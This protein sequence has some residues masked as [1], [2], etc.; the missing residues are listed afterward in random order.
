[1]LWGNLLR[2]AL[3]E[4]SGPEAL[5][6]ALRFF[7]AM[8]TSPSGTGF[9]FDAN[10]QSIMQY[11]ALRKPDSEQK[12]HQLV[13]LLAYLT[14]K[15][16]VLG[17]PLSD[18]SSLWL[19]EAALDWFFMLGR[20]KGLWFVPNRIKSFFKQVPGCHRWEAVAWLAWLSSENRDSDLTDKLQYGRLLSSIFRIV[21]RVGEGLSKSEISIAVH[22][23]LT[24][25]EDLPLDKALLK[26]VQLTLLIHAGAQNL[27][28]AFVR[29]LRRVLCDVPELA[30][31]AACMLYSKT[32]HL[33]PVHHIARDILQEPLPPEW[34]HYKSFYLINRAFLG[35]HLKDPSF[36]PSREWAIACTKQDMPP[37]SRFIGFAASG[38]WPEA[39][40]NSEGVVEQS[41]DI[42]S[43]APNSLARKLVDWADKVRERIKELAEQM[44]AGTRSWATLLLEFNQFSPPPDCPEYLHP[45]G[46]D[47]LEVCL[48][49]A[50]TLETVHP[51]PR[52]I[53][54]QFLNGIV[55]CAR[56]EDAYVSMLAALESYSRSSEL[57]AS[58]WLQQ[59]NKRM[60][61]NPTHGGLFDRYRTR[62]RNWWKRWE[63]HR[64]LAA[65]TAWIERIK[66]LPMEALQSQVSSVSPSKVLRLL[67]KH[68]TVTYCIPQ[69]H[70]EFFLL[71]AVRARWHIRYSFAKCLLDRDAFLEYEAWL[72]MKNRS[73]Y[74]LANEDTLFPKAEIRYFESVVKPLASVLAQVG[75]NA[76]FSYVPCLSVLAA[77]EKNYRAG[78]PPSVPARTL[79]EP[80]KNLESRHYPDVVT[81]VLSFKVCEERD[82]TLVTEFP[83]VPLFEHSKHLH[84]QANPS[85]LHWLRHNFFP[86]A[87]T[88]GLVGCRALQSFPKGIGQQTLMWEAIAVGFSGIFGSVVGFFEFSKQE[89]IDGLE[90]KE[91][92]D[93]EPPTSATLQEAALRHMTKHRP[94]QRMLGHLGAAEVSQGI[95]WPLKDRVNLIAGGG[96]VGAI[97]TSH[98]AYILKFR[99]E[100]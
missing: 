33:N 27:E 87:Q 90:F 71:S 42:F 64:E 18:F 11:R 77:M 36:V 6:T 79:I 99:S 12:T 76:P 84:A 59:I 56:R 47:F 46:I 52:S 100:P 45:K 94:G 35:Y 14:G 70:G 34:E 20:Q 23:G 24:K 98:L 9:F 28:E 29:S 37:L 95:V 81:A 41:A 88:L 72:S 66:A 89:L 61:P 17:I 49:M 25:F 5:Q 4:W 30:G 31:S 57:I 40:L 92:I 38:I 8:C 86:A 55:E 7:C 67:P 60:Q 44:L 74:E 96:F 26:F 32:N 58:K 93:Q 54:E 63:A 16:D 1:M 62:L 13:K 10:G 85:L 65:C 83:R 68:S 97:P 48:R 80:L 15:N 75:P 50:F 69:E 19:Q 53:M 43:L 39:I 78:I 22:F 3:A 51:V 82:G 73:S 2:N 21:E 91:G